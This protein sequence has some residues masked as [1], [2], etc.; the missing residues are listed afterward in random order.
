MT[1]ELT[2]AKD[3]IEQVINNIRNIRNKAKD[4]H[5]R[6]NLDKTGEDLV[7]TLHLINKRIFGCEN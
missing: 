5:L 4:S 2:D 1:T 3:Y 7:D 6:Q